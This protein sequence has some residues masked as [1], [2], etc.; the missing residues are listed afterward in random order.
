[1]WFPF[2]LAFSLKIIGYIIFRFSNS[3]KH[4]F[5]FSL[6]DK[7]FKKYRYIQTSINKKL[8]ISG[9]WGQARHINYTGDWLMGLSWCLMTGYD[10]FIPYFYAIYFFILLIHRDKRDFNSCLKKYGPDWHIYCTLVPYRFIP[11]VF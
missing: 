3:E 10:S 11:K 4:V 8:L 1:M 7:S 6:S 9:W 2:I 5:K